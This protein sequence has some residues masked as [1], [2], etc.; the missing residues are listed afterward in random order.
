MQG[1]RALIALQ[2][3][4]QPFAMAGPADVVVVIS[5]RRRPFADLKILGINLDGDFDGGSRVTQLSGFLIFVS[6]GSRRLLSHLVLIG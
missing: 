1:N 5:R 3:A 6:G 2:S 4:E